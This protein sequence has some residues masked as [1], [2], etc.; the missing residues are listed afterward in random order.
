M[1]TNNPG[2]SKTIFLYINAALLLTLIGAG[3]YY[4]VTLYTRGQSCFTVSQVQQDPRCLYIYNNKVFEKGTKASPHKGNPCGS[5]VSAIIPQSHI[6]DKTA[7]LDPN[8]RGDVCGLQAMPS[9]TP[10]PSPTTVPPTTTPI[11]T[12]ISPTEAQVVAT[13]TPTIPL[14][15]NFSPTPVSSESAELY[16]PTVEPTEIKTL[17]VTGKLEWLF[18]ALIP[19]ALVTLGVLM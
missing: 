18:I 4:A 10:S 15:E 19:V 7:R 14:V 13:A 6:L 5:D 3:T 9:A 8:Y 16:T 17:P 1:N 2:K 12:L 11:Q